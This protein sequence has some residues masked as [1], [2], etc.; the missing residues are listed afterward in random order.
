MISSQNT[1]LCLIRKA[2]ALTNALK[3]CSRSLNRKSFFFR[4]WHSAKR[5]IH[6][7]R[8]IRTAFLLDIYFRR[9]KWTSKYSRSYFCVELKYITDITSLENGVFFYSGYH[10]QRYSYITLCS[11]SLT[12]L[13][14]EVSKLLIFF[15]GG[16]SIRNCFIGAILSSRTEFE[17]RINACIAHS[18][19]WS[20]QESLFDHA[21][22]HRLS[23]DK[24][25]YFQFE[26][27][28]TACL[29]FPVRDLEIATERKAFHRVYHALSCRV[30]QAL[31]RGEAR[32]P[33]PPFPSPPFP[34]FPHSPLPVASA[35]ILPRGQRNLSL[36]SRK[37]VHSFHGSGW[38]NS[39]WRKE[40]KARPPEASEDSPCQRA[41]PGAETGAGATGKGENVCVPMVVMVIAFCFESDL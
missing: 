40:F 14:Q 19:Q 3:W 24:R 26:K 17:P 27:I 9:E 2:D 36:V 10:C 4:F 28:N 30:S 35:A 33:I 41:K 13:K 12:H 1:P 31:K 32:D 39:V 25:R 38:V 21:G 18:L 22:G 15:S 11:S 5:I 6:I 23:L 34:S 7:N 8:K 16:I 20:Q 29:Q 37:T